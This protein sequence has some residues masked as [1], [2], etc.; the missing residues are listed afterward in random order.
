ML[1]TQFRVST[2]DII[3]D[4]IRRDNLFNPRISEPASVL[5]QSRAQSLPGAGET[6]GSRVQRIKIPIRWPV[7]QI[8]KWRSSVT[9]FVM[10]D[11]PENFPRKPILNFLKVFTSSWS[12]DRY[13]WEGG[14]SVDL[15][16]WLANQITCLQSHLFLV[17]MPRRQLCWP[18]LEFD[19][20]YAESSL[21][22]LPT[23]FQSEISFGSP[24]FW[25]SSP[26]LLW[27]PWIYLETERWHKLTTAQVWTLKLING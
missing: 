25:G 24:S 12:R 17:P 13:F 8:S 10:V 9:C 16:Q 18:V 5:Q 27:S 20:C 11:F 2:L 15:A 3:F 7:Q 19:E 22:W 21:W 14:T 26:S 6:L 4:K 1:D 23:T